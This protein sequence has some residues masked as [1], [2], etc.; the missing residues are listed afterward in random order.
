MT[1]KQQTVPPTQKAPEAPN[2]NTV[3]G[4]LQNELVFMAQRMGFPDKK[5][6]TAKFAEMRKAVIVAGLVP[7]KPRTEM[8]IEEAKAL[9]AAIYETFLP[10]GIP[11]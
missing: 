3:D 9:V 7:D 11:A 2:P 4:Y 1:V 6:T 8:T 10:G 5:T